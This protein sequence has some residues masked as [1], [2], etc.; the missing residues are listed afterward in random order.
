MPPGFYGHP[1]LEAVGAVVG[2]GTDV[3]PVVSLVFSKKTVLELGRLDLEDVVLIY[4]E[5]PERKGER[6]R[7]KVERRREGG[8]EEQKERQKGVV[9]AF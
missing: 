8:E 1:Y 3:D 7:A 9:E 2:T 5:V 4:G 6:R